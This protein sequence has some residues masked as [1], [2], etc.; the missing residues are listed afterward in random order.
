MKKTIAIAFSLLLSQMAHASLDY[1]SISQQSHPGSMEFDQ[2]LLTASQMSE[3]KMWILDQGTLTEISF[4]E[5]NNSEFRS[6]E[7]KNVI[8]VSIPQN[9]NSKM[10]SIGV[11]KIEAADGAVPLKVLFQAAG[12]VDAGHPVVLLDVEHNV[13]VACV[14]VSAK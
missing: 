1:C 9:E 10:T 12:N 11:A 13:S 3:S 6:L 2:T 8:Y 14:S 5:M 4:E 7:G